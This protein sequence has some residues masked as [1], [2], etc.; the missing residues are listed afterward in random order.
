MNSYCCKEMGFHLEQEELPITYTPKYREYGIDYTDGSGS[1]QLINFCPWCGFRLPDKLSNEWFRSL[2]S[3]GLEPY[4]S[5]I[6]QEYRS[7]D[8][9]KKRKL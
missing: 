2:E 3:M 8:W 5:E 4:E 7:D 1:T 9:W 6:P